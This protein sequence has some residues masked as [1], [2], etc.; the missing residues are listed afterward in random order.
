MNLRAILAHCAI[1]LGV[2]LAG[3]MLDAGAFPGAFV[4]GAYFAREA[5]QRIE[6]DHFGWWRAIREVVRD[7]AD[8]MAQGL[9]P[10]VV[11]VAAV[12]AWRV[13]T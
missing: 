7:G 11:A 5:A 4:A 8:S 3:L 6:N 2:T 1:T 13:W 10:T 12:L 9:G